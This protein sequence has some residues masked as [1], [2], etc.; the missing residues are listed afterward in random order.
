MNAEAADFK[1]RQDVTLQRVSD[2]TEPMWIDPETA[3]DSTVRFGILFE[4][5]FH[6]VEEMINPARAHLSRLMNQISLG[7]HDHLVMTS[8]LRHDM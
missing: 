6:V 3:Q 2:H 4:N 5:D 7:D 8:D 1:N